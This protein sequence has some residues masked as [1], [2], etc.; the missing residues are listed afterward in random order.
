MR[1]PQNAHA[2]NAIAVLGDLRDPRI[3]DRLGTSHEAPA[4]GLAG[5]FVSPFAVRGGLGE[6]DPPA[7]EKGDAAEGGGTDAEQDRPQP[8]AS[9]IGYWHRPLP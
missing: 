6:A 4:E 1:T 5:F 3:F 7:I 8:I 2:K 9:G